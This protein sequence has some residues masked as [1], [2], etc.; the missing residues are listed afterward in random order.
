MRQDQARHAEVHHQQPDD[1]VASANALFGAHQHV[2]AQHQHR[3]AD[4]HPEAVAAQA[5]AGTVHRQAQQRLHGDV[6]EPADCEHGAYHRQRHT[7]VCR[8]VGRQMDRH[9]QRQGRDWQAGR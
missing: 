8:K 6:D 1:Q 2:E 3:R 9:R 7:H 4:Q 5:R